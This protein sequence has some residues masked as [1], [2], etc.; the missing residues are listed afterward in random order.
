MSNASTG[1]SRAAV[2][3]R[4]GVGEQEAADVAAGG[5]VEADHPTGR[6]SLNPGC[7]TF[8][9]PGTCFWSTAPA[10]KRALAS[11]TTLSWASSS[12]IRRRDRTRG[13][14]SKLFVALPHRSTHGAAA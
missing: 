12:L 6:R 4:D 7:S 2:D 5:A 9:Q 14:A 8:G 1:V 11:L 10:S 13:S 3:V